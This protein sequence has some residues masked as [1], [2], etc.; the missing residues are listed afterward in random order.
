MRKFSLS[1]SPTSASTSRWTINDR[2][3]P[4]ADTKEPCDLSVMNQLV[5]IGLLL[6]M[7]GGCAN[8]D[9]RQ[10]LTDEQFAAAKRACGA[11]DAHMVR[12]SPRPTVTLKRNDASLEATQAQARCL[13]SKLKGTDADFV[14]F[15]GEAP[16][17][18]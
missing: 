12:G 2:F 10:P 8:G 16:A 11:P 6:G 5:K 9:G 4:I 1:G 18:R 15:I 13:A 17:P 3:P 14:V 7:L